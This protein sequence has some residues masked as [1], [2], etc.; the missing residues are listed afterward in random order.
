MRRPDSRRRAVVAGVPSAATA[1][2][3]PVLGN[4][5]AALWYAAVV[6]PEAQTAIH[7]ELHSPGKSWVAPRRILALMASIGY[8][9][10]LPAAVVFQS[11]GCQTSK[12]IAMLP[13]VLNPPTLLIGTVLTAEV[14]GALVGKALAPFKKAL[15]VVRRNTRK[16]E[17]D[18]EPSR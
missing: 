10:S 12:R 1:A 9:A 15:G 7:R 4:G 2:V 6:L 3:K 16:L 18:A 17:G 8:V 14:L 13:I 11:L 5:I